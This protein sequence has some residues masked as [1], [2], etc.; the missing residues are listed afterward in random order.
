[1]HFAAGGASLTSLVETDVGASMRSVGSSG[2][3]RVPLTVPAGLDLDQLA[4]TMRD[5][6]GFVA[7]LN[8]V[9]VVRRNAPVGTLDHQSQ[10]VAPR[11]FGQV[12]IAETIDLSASIPL[13]SPGENLLAI[14][15]LNFTA[16]D[17]TFLIQPRLD[18]SR[19]SQARRRTAGRGVQRDLV[20]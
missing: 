7:Y 1:M 10:A 14:H 12:F 16:D 13:L 20:C 2:Y 15:G 5:D 6:D 11:G 9:E 19:P 17:G 4:L 3:L 8:G 18:A